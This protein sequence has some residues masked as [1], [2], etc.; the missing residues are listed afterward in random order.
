MNRRAPEHSLPLF[1]LAVALIPAF[2]EA[3]GVVW[4]A[5]WCLTFGLYFTSALLGVLSVWFMVGWGSWRPSLLE[6]GVGLLSVLLLCAVG[7]GAI[8]LLHPP[9]ASASFVEIS[10]KTKPFV[11]DA[12]LG[13][14]FAS[15]QILEWR[16]GSANGRYRLNA[17]GFRVVTSTAARV[18]GVLHP[19]IA[20]I[21][22]RLT[23]GGE[24]ASSATFASRVGAGL[25]LTSINLAVPGYGFGQ[26]LHLLQDEALP[27]KPKVV[28]VAFAD[29][30]CVDAAVAPSA[31]QT[32]DQPRYTVTE[33]GL[34]LGEPNPPPGDVFRWLDAQ[35][36]LWRGLWQVDSF[37][38][39][40]IP[41]GERTLARRRLLIRMYRTA[42]TAEVPILFVRLPAPT[43]FEHPFLQD[44]FHAIGAMYLDLGHSGIRR[45]RKVRTD[46][47]RYLSPEGHAWVAQEV[48]RS[49][50]R[51]LDG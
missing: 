11:T 44:T 7:E 28:V 4:L 13:W 8:R 27:Q 47:G 49:L 25:K 24:V 33:T 38:G 3:Q 48:R 32:W 43:A 50:N 21:G 34:H 40:Y 37:F 45:P 14:R 1:L 41:W 31:V 12:R 39:R 20:F 30:T 19:T 10:G 15:D 22:D 26:Q 18:K 51:L 9:A 2:W 16:R 6:I 17:K 35:S 23:F 29:P 5:P 46:D 36:E 42:K